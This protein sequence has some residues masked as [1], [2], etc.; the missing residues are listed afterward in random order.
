MADLAAT[1]GPAQGSSRQNG[2]FVGTNF[3]RQNGVAGHQKEVSW[4]IVVAS[5]GILG[6]NLASVAATFAAQ[7]HAKKQHIQHQ[8]DQKSI[9]IRSKIPSPR[10]GSTFSE[11]DCYSYRGRAQKSI[12]IVTNEQVTTRSTRVHSS[13]VSSRDPDSSP[14]PWWWCQRT[15]TFA[16]THPQTPSWA[17]AGSAR[18]RGQRP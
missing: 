11:V 5:L 17:S 18:A 8:I 3:G 14:P 2:H 1:F 4:A 13:L 15:Q 10:A 12:V 7:I 9:P 16:S 6:V